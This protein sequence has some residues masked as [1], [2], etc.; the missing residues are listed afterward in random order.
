MVPADGDLTARFKQL[1]REGQRIFITDLPA[2]KLLS[3]AGL[4]EAEDVLIFNASA[5]DD[6]LRNDKCR[7]NVLH[8]APSR[9]MLADAAAQFLVRKNWKRWFLVTGPEEGDRLFSA[10]MRRAA[11]R[12][13]GKIVEE[14]QWTFTHDFRRTADKEIPLFTQEVDYEVLL[15]TDER[16]RFGDYLTYRT[17]NPRLVAGSA[18]LVPTTWHRAHEQWGANQLQSR[19]LKFAGRRMTDL[20]YNAWTAVRSVS[21]A[22]TRTDATDVP[23]IRRYVLSAEFELAAFKGVPLSYRDWNGQLRQPILLVT[24]RSLVSVSPQRGFLHPVTP[25]DSLGYDRP[26]TTCRLE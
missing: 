22:V 23:T 26:E 18:G 25:L 4:P 14:K 11:Q 15:V 5:R 7:K 13:G 6:A 10:D 19:F 24:P 17:W 16:R 1:V 9:A 21:E 3:L 2:P 12:F 20:D 8:T